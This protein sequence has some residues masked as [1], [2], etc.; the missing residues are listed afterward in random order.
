MKTTM[1]MFAAMTL[2]VVAVANSVSAQNSWSF[3]MLGDT[4]G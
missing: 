2:V 4:R 3:V 1:K